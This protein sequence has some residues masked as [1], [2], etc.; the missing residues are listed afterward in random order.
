[1]ICYN[2]VIK[3]Q[4]RSKYRMKH[5]KLKLTD[6]EDRGFKLGDWIELAG[7]ILALLVFA[8]LGFSVFVAVLKLMTELAG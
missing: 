4:Q 5:N 2:Q 7:L 1:M 8:V 6:T 3:F